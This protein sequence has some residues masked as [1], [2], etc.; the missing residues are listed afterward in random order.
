M[1]WREK[2]RRLLFFDFGK[3]LRFLFLFFRA[4]YV[5]RLQFITVDLFKFLVFPQRQLLHFAELRH[6]SL[7]A[8]K[9]VSAQ[10]K[11]SLSVF[12]AHFN[13]IYRLAVLVHL[14]HDGKGFGLLFS[15][16]FLRYY[17]LCNAL[18]V[19]NRLEQGVRIF[20]D[21]ALPRTD[22]RAVVF[23]LLVR[24][25]YAQVLFKKH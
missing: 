8:P 22:I 20:F 16:L 25:C 9:R 11:L 17:I 14:F 18:G 1:A 12:G 2:Y 4:F 6:K 5:A 21:F 10:R 19:G 15:C 3:P 24:G 13:L 23:D 7:T